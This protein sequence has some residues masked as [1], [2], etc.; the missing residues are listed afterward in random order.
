MS[1]PVV[2]WLPSTPRIFQQMNEKPPLKVASDAGTVPA[3]PC[4]VYVSK[5][6]SGVF[7]R[8]ANLAGIEAEASHERE[9]LGKIVPLFKAKVAR[10]HAEESPIEWIDPP[11]P[12]GPEEVKRFIPVHL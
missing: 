12:I 2:W 3:F 1:E 8:V 11:L 7:A 10:L 5:R 6:E 9:V 4:I